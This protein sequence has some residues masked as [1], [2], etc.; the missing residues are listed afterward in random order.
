MATLERV[1]SQNLLKIVLASFAYASAIRP[2]RELLLQHF[3][4]VMGIFAHGPSKHPRDPRTKPPE[5]EQPYYPKNKTIPKGLTKAAGSIYE[6]I[7]QIVE[8][9]NRSGQK[10][11]KIVIITDLAKDFDDLLAMIA[12]KELHRLGAIELE[13]F[14]ANLYPAE[15]RARLGRGALDNLGL[16]DIPI[17]EGTPGE[18]TAN[19]QVLEYEFEGSET[20][21]APEGT[22]LPDGQTLLHD[23]FTRARDGDYKVTLLTLSSLL[24][25]AEFEKLEPDL[26]KTAVGRVVLQGGYS[27]IDGKLEADQAAANN[28]FSIEAARRFHGFMQDN[29]IPSTCFT[30]VATF[31][32]PIYQTF[33]EELEKTELEVGV[34]LRAVQLGQ[35]LHYWKCASGPPE[36]RF[37]P[38]MDEPWFLSVK[39]TWYEKHEF[40]EP[41]PPGDKITPWLDKVTAYD[42]LAAIGAAGE[43]ILEVLG[44]TKPIVV[45]KDAIH[46]IHKVVGVLPVEDPKDKTKNKPE[47]A[48]VNGNA[49]AVA[50][51]ALVLGS[52]LSVQQGLEGC[53]T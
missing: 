45:R 3:E 23:I 20:F 26:L 4:Y 1:Y 50:I 34:Y 40:D 8:Q 30:K 7:L 2:T 38:F 28:N 13:G 24:D 31:A 32:T 12:L 48:N 35:D 10:P 9:R 11:P 42:C 25:I 43:D 16:Q 18:P 39:T 6:S 27:I 53:Q 41:G 5:E 49:F 17:A 36:G 19:H 29:K 46:P 51:K 22:P 14:V 15:K 47:E 33:L 44:V 37:R 52:L 21:I